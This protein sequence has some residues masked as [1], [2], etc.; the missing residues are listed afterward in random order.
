MTD[1]HPGKTIPVS[2]IAVK[3][4]RVFNL[5][6]LLKEQRSLSLDNGQFIGSKCSL[7]PVQEKIPE[8]RMILVTP[9]RS[10]RV[11]P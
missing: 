5:S 8:Q 4:C 6:G 9:V 3:P 11:F 7:R 2:G 10:R 1:H